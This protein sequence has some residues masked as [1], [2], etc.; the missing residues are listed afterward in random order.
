MNRCD[1]HILKTPNL[2]LEALD[3]RRPPSGN[4]LHCIH[5]SPTARHPAPPPVAW[6][7]PH[8]RILVTHTQ[9]QGPASGMDVK[10][11]LPRGSGRA[12]ITGPDLLSSQ[13][14]WRTG[15]AGPFSGIPRHGNRQA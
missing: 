3:R 5:T 2:L 8:P 15:R 10:P 12:L 7:L 13:R 6:T 14:S 11:A 1:L 4:L 9:A